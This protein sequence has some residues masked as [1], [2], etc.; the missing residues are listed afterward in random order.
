MKKLFVLTVAGLVTAGLC[1]Q[2]QKHTPDS[3]ARSAEQTA[4]QDE[5]MPLMS[6]AYSLHLP[7]SR[8]GSGTSW[9]PDAS[10]MYMYIKGNNRSSWMIH[11]NIVLRYN[12]QDVFNKSSRGGNKVDA[13]NWFM[14]MYNRRVG[15][16]GLLN[17]TAMIS[18]DPL[19]VGESGYPLLFQTGETYNGERLIDRQHPHDLFSGLSIAYTHSL[20]RDADV[21]AYIG[22]PGEPA[23][24]PVAF[25]HRISALNN[26]NAPLGHHWQDATHTTFGV[27]TLG[28]RYKKFK[29]EGSVFTG[30]EPDE[31]RYNFEKARFDSY[32][33]R[34]SFNPNET[35]AIQFSQGFLNQPELSEP[36]VDLVRTTASIIRS[37]SLRTMNWSHTLAIGMND[38]TQHE[39]NEYSLLYETNLQFQRQAL[40]AR[41]EYVKK[42]ADD[43]G[44]QLS[45]N[46]ELFN[47]NAVT[48]GYNFNISPAAPVDVLLG[49]Q[50]TLN[51][52]G[53]GLKSIYGSLPVGAQIYLQLRPRRHQQ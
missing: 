29:L 21:T 32:S 14:G 5:G 2:E 51:F 27:G 43:L 22:Y 53:A 48:L 15:S 39:H 24:G 3:T 19:T 7:M 35:W 10:P 38:K 17:A 1:A 26:A 49:A 47:I 50:G 11:G 12:K 46:G 13:P 8:N 37:T 18:L 33:Y 9:L 44:L 28:I 34:L 23:L 36:G 6:H 20:S 41:Y 16:K 52:P 45:H 40:Y 42:S 30:R 31:D 25:M 4:T